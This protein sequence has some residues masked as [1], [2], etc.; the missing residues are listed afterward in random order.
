MKI[1]VDAFGGDNAPLEILKGCELA[2]NELGVEII[3][4]GNEEIINKVMSENGISKHKMEIVNAQSVITM[5]DDP[6]AVL[7]Q[8]KDSSMAIGLSLLSEGKGDAFVTAGSTGA[9]LSGATLIV[10]R[11]KG[12]KRAAL[13]PLL[14]TNNGYAMLIDCGA[15]IENKAEY[16]AQFGVMGSAYMEKIMKVKNP[17]VGLVNNG[18][19]ETKGGELQLEAFKQLK[20]MP[21]NFIGNIEGRDIPLGTADVVVA[22]GFTGNVILKTVEG[23]GIAF[24][25]NLKDVFYKNIKTKIAALLLKNELKEFKK[26]M[27]YTETGGAPLMGI[28]KPVIK[29]HGSSNAKAFKN[30]IRQAKLFCENGVIK[31]IEDYLESAK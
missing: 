19:E 28:A 15:N 23:M 20:E 12:I 25:K 17:K 30:A 24:S 18:T 11:I 16:L 31:A 8:K 1:I 26:K 6:T 21:I 3:L 10:K 13:A 5:E 9:V 29:A 27:D 4:T 7:R 22:D 2:V 14:P